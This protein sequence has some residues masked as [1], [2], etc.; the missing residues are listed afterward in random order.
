MAI[1]GRCAE[2]EFAGWGSCG[3]REGS[4]NGVRDGSGGGR[5]SAT[6]IAMILEEHCGI[7]VGRGGGAGVATREGGYS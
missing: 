4:Q 6:A 5:E 7:S 2:V 3:R 1:R